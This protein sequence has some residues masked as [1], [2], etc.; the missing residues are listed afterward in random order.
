MA[1][2]RVGSSESAKMSAVVDDTVGRI[3]RCKAV[4]NR[5]VSDRGSRSAGHRAG[6]LGRDP[7][8]TAS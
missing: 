3:A 7:E 2:M 8:V 1:A 5:D 4:T 6:P